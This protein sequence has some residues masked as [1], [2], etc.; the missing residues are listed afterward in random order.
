[1]RGELVGYVLTFISLAATMPM[2]RPTNFAGAIPLISTPF[3][4]AQSTKRV[5]F[6]PGSSAAAMS[7]LIVDLD[8]R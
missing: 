5:C 4:H 1:M 2:P 7:L 8:E 6:S 3:L